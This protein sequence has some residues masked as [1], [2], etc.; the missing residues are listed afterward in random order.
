MALNKVIYPLVVNGGINTKIDEHL[1]TPDYNLEI[2]NADLDKMG[3]NIKRNGFA[4]MTDGIKGGG[5][6]SSKNPSFVIEHNDEMLVGVSSPDN[7]L[8]S[9]NKNEDEWILKDGQLVSSFVFV[10][11]RIGDEINTYSP[12]CYELPS[13]NK[14]VFAY[15]TNNESLTALVTKVKVYTQD[16][17]TKEKRIIY[18]D[19]Q[20]Q[21]SGTHYYYQNC[22][23]RAYDQAIPNIFLIYCRQN[24]ATYELVCRTMD[25]DGTLIK[26]VVVYSSSPRVINF[27]SC[28]V[29]NVLFIANDASALTDTINTRISTSTGNILLSA[30]ITTTAK[31]NT[32][33][34]CIAVKN[35]GLY[36][37]V[38]FVTDNTTV[39]SPVCIYGLTTGLVVN[40]AQFN[41]A[42]VINA[43]SG[44]V[45]IDVVDSGTKL[46][47]VHQSLNSKSP[48][49][50][51][52][53]AMNS[54]EIMSSIVDIGTRVESLSALYTDSAAMVSSLF[55]IDSTDNRYFIA[56][57]MI[58]LFEK[59]Y[60]Y[61]VRYPYVDDSLLKV[62]TFAVNGVATLDKKTA[63]VY[64]GKNYILPDVSIGKD[65]DFYFPSLYNVRAIALETAT[66][67]NAVNYIGNMVINRLEFDSEYNGINAKL[68]NNTYLTGA[69]IK[70]YDGMQLLEQSF[71]DSNFLF[72]AQTAN[73]GMAAGTYQYTAI[74]EY[75]DA[76]GQTHRS[77]PF[78]PQEIVTNAAKSILLTFLYPNTLGF[79]LV[80]GSKKYRIII[81]RTKSNAPGVYYRVGGGN[82]ENY[83]YGVSAYTYEDITADSDLEKA[84]R[85]YTSGGV[86]PN[87]YLPPIKHMINTN[88]RIFALS[89]EDENLVFYSQPYLY[90]E[91]VNFSEAL[92]LRIDG[93]ILNRSG[94]GMALASIDSKIICLKDQSIVYFYGKGPNFTGEQNDYSDPAL[95]SS[96]VG[97]ADIKSIVT[98]P[99][100]IMFK[101]NK[102]IY[103]L[104][105][106]LQLTYAGAAVEQYN[107]EK[108]IGTASLIDKHTVLFMTANRT[109]AYDYSQEKWRSWSIFGK[110][111]STYKKLPVFIGNDYRIYSQDVSIYKDGTN[112]YSMKMKTPW[113]KLSGIQNF[114]R[115]YKIMILGRF[116]SAH[117]LTV[118]IYHDYDDTNFETHTIL[119][120]ASDKIY[121]Y[122]LSP[123]F[124]KGESFKIEIYD[125]C[126]SGSGQG[127][128]LTNLSLVMGQK[129]GT[130]KIENRRQY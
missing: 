72:L 1:V 43:K 94:I 76:S 111:L 81:Y 113:I 127:F 49:E 80:Q 51:A 26:Q 21:A 79:S 30:Q 42:K 46:L 90:G 91:C 45:D 40:F 9:Y 8:Y 114:Q 117:T 88:G 36:T 116:K 54:D 39:A 119:P 4:Q 14:R 99:D 105:R 44:K 57:S 63:T 77:A 73:A 104:N 110:A 124:Q 96:D 64:T 84:E 58:P 120:L 35:Y 74:Y 70:E 93:G 59:Y 28:F 78:T 118:K 18:E 85:I 12:S 19:T 50:P 22:Q 32:T 29:G 103:L 129:K 68:G 108:I 112:Y 33:F 101:S 107:N 86:L 2:D 34:S 130:I 47:I 20:K 10:E 121:Q 15:V 62:G 122:D 123:A 71:I 115:I 83:L 37:F 97:L 41:I 24:G 48:Y 128:D 87:D 6:L 38:A 95:I 69:G 13:K 17:D 61:K 5:T 11:D 25:I 27:D 66:D 31:K 55:S 3:A 23:I 56:Q 82:R 53:V 92:S 100:G 67:I 98:I 60:I 65:S 89:S 16:Y 109:L 126:S 102:G 75:I 52:K 7:E 106:S 125:N